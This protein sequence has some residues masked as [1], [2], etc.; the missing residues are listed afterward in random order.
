VSFV[1]VKESSENERKRCLAL[2][3]GGGRGAWSIGYAL[4]IFRLKSSL[5]SIT[6]VMNVF[7]LC[8]G[9]CG[10]NTFA[11]ACEHVTNFSVAHESRNVISEDRL[12]YPNDHIEVD[13]RLSWF[14]GRLDR[15][16]G[17][18]AF[19]VHLKR[20]REKTAE[21]FTR[22]YGQGIIKAY[23][24][25]IVREHSMASPIDMCRHYCDTVNTNIELFL[26]DKSRSMEFRLE[27]A[28]EDFREFWD[29][30]GAEG[31]LSSSLQEWNRKYNASDPEEAPEEDSEEDSLAL[32]IRAAKKAVRVVRKFPHFVRAA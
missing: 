16:Y 5:S 2:F 21:S 30:I 15:R 24:K 7:V 22:R 14:L 6:D 26:N 10:S 27:S 13:N 25:N 11:R 9:R 3:A 12:G 8:T 28:D 23:R 1:L 19:Y 29:R 32:P 17:D 20:N 4:F 18:D 31:S